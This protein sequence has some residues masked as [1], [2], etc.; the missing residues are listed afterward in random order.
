MNQH[1][2]VEVGDADW[3]PFRIAFLQYASDPMTFFSVQSLYREP[4]WMRRPATA[5]IL[6]PSTAPRYLLRRRAKQR[7]T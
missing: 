1:G 2:G 6:R 7:K 3:G 5:T 4:E